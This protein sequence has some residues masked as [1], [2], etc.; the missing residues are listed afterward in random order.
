MTRGKRLNNYFEIETLEIPLALLCGTLYKMLLYRLV[1]DHVI[2]VVRVGCGHS[3]IN[4][5]P[6]QRNKAYLV[7]HI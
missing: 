7:S 6:L 3:T 5:K 1:M 4:L 2:S